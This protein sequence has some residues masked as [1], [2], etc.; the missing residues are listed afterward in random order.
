[1]KRLLLLLPLILLFAACVAPMGEMAESDMAMDEMAM[2]EMDEMP[3]ITEGELTVVNVRANL[4]LPSDTGSLWM[5][6]LNGT[7]T[8]EALLGAEIPGCGVVELHDMKIENDVMI[9]RPVEGGQIPI[10]AGEI[11]ELKRGGLHVMC[12]NKAEALEIGSM[13]DIVLRFANAGDV[14]V[15]GEVVPAGGMAMDHGDMEMDHDADGEEHGEGH[16]DMD[17]D[18]KADEDEQTDD[19]D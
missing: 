10:P 6:I 11:V 3:E 15:M 8:D 2:E 5:Y 17:M 16:E 13:V 14:P 18:D 9:M 12:I 7:D 1:M 19:D 4:S